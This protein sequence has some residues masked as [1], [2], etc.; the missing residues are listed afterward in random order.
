[1]E[2]LKLKQLK[3]QNIAGWHDVYV[4]LSFIGKGLYQ[5]LGMITVKQSMY[6]KM[7][8]GKSSERVVLYH[9][10]IWSLSIVNFWFN[11]RVFYESDLKIDD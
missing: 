3:L 2:C 8:L 1:M 4:N 10:G 6:H 9:L 11:K 7:L 5:S